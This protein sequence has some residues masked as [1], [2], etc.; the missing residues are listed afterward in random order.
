MAWAMTPQYRLP[1]RDSMLKTFVSGSKKLIKKFKG[2]LFAFNI[3]LSA[4]VEYWT[5]SKG[6]RGGLA[7]RLQEWP[8]K[9]ALEA[10][11]DPGKIALFV[12]FAEDLTLSNRAYLQTLIRA[13][14]AVMYISN[15][16]LRPSGREALAAL[17]WRLFERHNLGRDVGAF[18]DGVLWLE[19]HGWLAKIE[20]LIIAN[21][22]MQFLPGRYA[23]SLIDELR[24]FENSDDN[25]LFSHISH[26]HYTHYQSY[27]QALKPAIFRSSLFLQFWRDYI[28]LSHRGHCIF[29]G[30]IALSVNVYRRFKNVRVLYTSNGLLGVLEKLLAEGHGLSGPVALRL[31]PSVARTMQRGQ[32]S[33]SLHQIL[34]R[35]DQEEPL[36]G[37][38]L[39]C[40]VEIIEN[41]NP[42][43]VAAFLYPVYLHCPLVKQDLCVA[44]SF[45]LAQAISLYREALLDSSANC[46]ETI[47]V[48][49][50]AN[51]YARVLY[52][53]GTPMSFVNKPRESAVKG[54]TG[55]FVYGPVYDGNF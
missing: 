55:G 25:G 11:H 27:F 36:P 34:K 14:Y 39:Y 12:G 46:E 18:R 6:W 24:A 15:Y 35:G 42:S 22:S 38:V 19:E 54:I 48:D 44:G 33:Y 49:A 30:E 5:S 50:Y 47:E 10:T 51:E 52:A 37:W 23:K 53:K 3:Y 32:A 9:V 8:T 20:T 28:P 43:H 21:D 26:A 4:V 1:L 41:N 2:K 7:S 16:P 45:S 29:N 31:M 17:V 40:L 13:G